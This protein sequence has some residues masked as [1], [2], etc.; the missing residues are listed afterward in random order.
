MTRLAAIEIVYI[1]ADGPCRESNGGQ[2]GRWTFGETAALSLSLSL[3]G[4]ADQTVVSA[5][6]TLANCTD[7]QHS[8][9]RMTSEA[10]PASGKWQKLF[11]VEKAEGLGLK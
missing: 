6:L 4:I 8:W 9:Y 2:D 3:G 7:P 11:K 10:I 1:M 5:M